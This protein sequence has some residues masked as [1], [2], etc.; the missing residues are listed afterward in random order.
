M[1]RTTVMKELLLSVFAGQK[2]W[3]DCCNESNPKAQTAISS[4]T[5]GVKGHL[6]NKW[7]VVHTCK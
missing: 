4:D 6:Q 3:S 1:N 5:W 7:F 2:F